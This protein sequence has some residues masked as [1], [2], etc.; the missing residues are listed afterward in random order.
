[1]G[2]LIYLP[3]ALHMYVA[4]FWWYGPPAGWE[5]ASEPESLEDCIK[6]RDHIHFRGSALEIQSEG[7]AKDKN[8]AAHTDRCVLVTPRRRG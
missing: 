2:N 7:Y 5:F 6:S 4:V 8:R 3:V 1:M